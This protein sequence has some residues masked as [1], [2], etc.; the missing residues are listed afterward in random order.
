MNTH[1]TDGI[2]TKHVRQSASPIGSTSLVDGKRFLD[3]GSNFAKR[4]LWNTYTACTRVDPDF[5]TWSSHVPEVH[6]DFISV[7]YQSLPLTA[8]R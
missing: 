4:R 8:D 7:L 2:I 6:S 1:I 5:K 3:S